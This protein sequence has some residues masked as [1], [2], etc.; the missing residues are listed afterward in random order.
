MKG[1]GRSGIR[2]VGLYARARIPYLEFQFQEDPM[3]ETMLAAMVTA[4]GRVE[5]AQV[6]RP[7]LGPYDAD[8]H[9]G[10]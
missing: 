5:A 1:A 2:T 9:A 3:S 7:K 10:V 8:A 4:P 6:P